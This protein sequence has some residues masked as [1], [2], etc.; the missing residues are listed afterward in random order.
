MRKNSNIDCY[1][2]KGHPD[3]VK[4]EFLEDDTLWIRVPETLGTVYEKTLRA[5]ESFVPRLHTYDFVY[6]SNLSTFVSF[7]HLLQ[8]CQDLP[9]TNCCAAMIGGLPS[10]D[11]KRHSLESKFTFPSGNGFILSPD[12]VRRLV[13]EKIPLVEQ[14]DVTIG[15]ALQNWGIKIAEFVR[16]DF[17]DDGYWFVNN[18]KLLPPNEQNLD[19]KKIM[20]SYRIKSFDRMKD[21]DVMASLIRKVYA[22]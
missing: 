6:R 15:V 22:V 12:L 21:V 7:P 16:P 11:V 1:F 5:F 20:F 14:D 13:V 18:Y 17:R 19:P 2:Y 10:E 9:R 8:Y 4:E 3:L